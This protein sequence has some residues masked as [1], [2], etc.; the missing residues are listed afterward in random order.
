MRHEIPQVVDAV[1][2]GQRGDE[3]K[4]KITDDLACDP[5]TTHVVRF[6][7]ADNAGH[8]LLIGDQE[9]DVH[10]LP[11]GILHEDVMNVVGNGVLVNPHHTALEIAGFQRLGVPLGVENLAISSIASMILP[12]HIELDRLRE[13]GAGKQGSTVRG[14]AFAASDNAKREGVLTE[15]LLTKSGR[16]ELAEKVEAGLWA[17]NE[18]AYALGREDL[19]RSNVANATKY[20]MRKAMEL[21]PYITDTTT[22]LREAV[23][24]GDGVVAEGAQAMSLD[25]NYGQYP[26]VSSSNPGVAGML[27]GMGIPH[28]SVRNVYMVAKIMRS[29]VGG[30][31]FI[32][33]ETQDQELLDRL[34]GRRGDVDAEYGTSTGR[35]RRMGYFDIP[36]LRTATYLNDADSL[37]LTKLDLAPR[38]GETIKIATG[39]ETSDGVVDYAPAGSA[40]Q[41][42]ACSPVYEELPLW[43]Q[44]ISGARS[45]KDLPKKAK[46]LVNFIEDAVGIEVRYIGVGPGRDQLIKR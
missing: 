7:G 38:F 39:Y 30:G 12:H 27:S 34:V 41:L 17:T 46:H 3:G 23:L 26:C 8:T 31:P 36:E 32:T 11:S 1:I 37:V 5:N 45:F 42:E 35:R 29:H 33:E 15:N 10:G 9:Y 4:G 28:S 25:V 13:V 18:Q 24:R 19:V 2:G 14:V 6:N 16:R 22:M 40:K 43:S 21:I 44:D 20:W